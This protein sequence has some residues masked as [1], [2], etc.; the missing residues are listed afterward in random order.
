MD[1][2][3]IWNQAKVVFD[4][5]GFSFQTKAP[6]YPYIVLLRLSTAEAIKVADFINTKTGEIIG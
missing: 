5:F 1:E 2:L 6:E 4:G 3:Q